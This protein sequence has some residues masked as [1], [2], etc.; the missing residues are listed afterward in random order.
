MLSVCL[1]H[2]SGVMVNFSPPQYDVSSVTLCY[3]SVCVNPDLLTGYLDRGLQRAKM[4]DTYL[5]E[6]VHTKESKTNLRKLQKT[7]GGGWEHI[8]L[9]IC[10]M[11]AS[12]SAEQVAL[13]CKSSLKA[14]R[15]VPGFRQVESIWV[16][17]RWRRGPPALSLKNRCAQ[18]VQNSVPAILPLSPWESAD[19]RKPDKSLAHQDV[20]GNAQSLEDQLLGSG[21]Q[22]QWILTICVFCI[23][24]VK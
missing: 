11:P 13:P 5:D 24:G 22:G 16:C 2:L 20:V 9:S 6:M 8:L 4:T 17:V 3:S 21:P 1:L 15:P 14:V 19:P 10:R 12:L 18:L 23:H 7:W